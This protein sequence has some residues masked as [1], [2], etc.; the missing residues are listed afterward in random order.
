MENIKEITVSQKT[1]IENVIYTCIKYLEKK[2]G[3]VKLYAI[4]N[5]RIN[6]REIVDKILIKRSNI[7][8]YKYAYWRRNTEEIILTL[9]TKIEDPNYKLIENINKKENGNKIKDRNTLSIKKYLKKNNNSINK[10]NKDEIII[11]Y[12]NY[13][14]RS[15]KLFDWEFVKNNKNHCK[16]L[17]DNKELD[18][19]DTLP[20]QYNYDYNYIYNRELTNKYVEIKL[21]GMENVTDM[22]YM[23]YKC[24]DLLSVSNIS[25]LD[26]SKVKNMSCLFYDCESLLLP[27]IL[28][29]DTSKVTDISFMLY[30]CKSLNYKP[31]I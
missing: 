19:V 27:E 24:K 1:N 6:L 14:F 12:K 22:S 31:D 21:K 23:F 2:K 8:K 10:L 3:M 16:I 17:L 15:L 30:N 26:T 29:W 28:N 20:I 9:E 13:Y 25:D 18:L 11:R 5:A 4:G 7:Y